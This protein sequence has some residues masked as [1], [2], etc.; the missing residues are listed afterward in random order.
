MESLGVVS[1]PTAGLVVM[2]KKC[3]DVRLCVDLKAISESVIRGNPPDPQGGGH[4]S[5]T[6]RS[7]NLHKAQQIPLAKESRLLT[8][9]ITLFGRYAFNKLPVL[10]SCSRRGSTLSWKGC[11]MDEILV[12]GKDKEHDQRLIQVLRRLES[13][14][15]TLNPKEM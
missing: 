5:S 9:F 3:G 2:P 14:N 6:V 12:F 10:P 7:R 8:I 15:V 4:T 13:A 11:Q 1:K